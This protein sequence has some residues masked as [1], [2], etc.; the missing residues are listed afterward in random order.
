MNGPATQA[1]TGNTNPGQSMDISVNL[2]APASPGDYTGYWKLRDGS[3]V[4]FDQFYVQIKV[5]NAATATNTL[6]PAIAQVVLTNIYGEGG[7]VRSD[8]AV[9]GPPNAGDT[10]SNAVAEAFV[11]F[12]M[13]GIPSGANITKVVVDFSNGYDTLGNPWDLGG[14]CL[15]AYPQNYGTLDAGD[16]VPGDPVG[17][18]IAWCGAGALSSS[19]ESADIKSTVQSAVGT[20]RL[21]LRIQFRAPMTDNDGVIDMVRLGTMKLIVTYQ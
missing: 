16:F 4:L 19:F 8:G 18:V 5:Q 10:D 20:S 2:T 6:S 12:D 1:L 7:Q 21:R 11:S 13:T 14:G 3:G 17:A 9:L 15:R